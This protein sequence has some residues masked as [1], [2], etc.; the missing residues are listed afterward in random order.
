MEEVVQVK[1]VHRGDGSAADK[2]LSAAAAGEIRL[3]QRDIA[4][5]DPEPG[6]VEDAVL[7]VLPG[8]RLRRELKP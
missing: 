4:D 5:P 2:Q 6:Y 3:R 1:K 8:W 7:V